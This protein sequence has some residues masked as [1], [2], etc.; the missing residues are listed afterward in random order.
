MSLMIFYSCC[1]ITCVV[2]AVLF[3]SILRHRHA[4]TKKSVELLWTLVPFVILI[5]M[6]VP[7]S[8]Q[9]LHDPVQHKLVNTTLQD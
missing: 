6:A 2:F 8:R 7:A 3:I 5:L 9:L 1:V 4:N